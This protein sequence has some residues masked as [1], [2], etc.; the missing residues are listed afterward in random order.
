MNTGL[1]HTEAPRHRGLFFNAPHALLFSVTTLVALSAVAAA[2]TPAAP[3]AAPTGNTQRGKVVYETT[4][5]CFACHGYDGQTGSPRLVPM[6]RSEDI[7]LTYVRK[8]ATPGMPSFATVPEQ[9]L[10]DAYAYIRSIPQAAPAPDSVPLIKGILDR[11]T[12]AN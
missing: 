8:P 11:R 6:A 12:K 4:L 9:Q 5:R 10:R 3:L 1:R 7:F 2:Q